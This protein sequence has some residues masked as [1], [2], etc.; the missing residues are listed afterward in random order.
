M[1]SDGLNAGQILAPQVSEQY[2]VGAKATVGETL[3]TLAFFNI[4]KPNNYK[5]SLGYYTQD[6]RQENN[7]M[8]F[9][10]T[11][12]VVPELT[13]V[14][15]I[16]LLDPKVKKTSVAANEGNA[17]TNVAKQLAKV[18]AEYDLDAVPGLALTG[19]A[20]YTGCLLYTSDAADE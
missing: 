12:K 17:P 3:F 11:G 15:G 14:G 8:E 16:T 6:G 4:D 13:V 7:G 18:Y 19:G 10:V 9:S 5:N 1:P 20:Y 2:E